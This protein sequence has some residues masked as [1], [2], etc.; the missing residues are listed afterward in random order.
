MILTVKYYNFFINFAFS[1]CLRLDQEKVVKEGKEQL[2]ALENELKDK[3][4]GGKT[5][6]LVDLV[7]DFLAY[8]LLII[9]EVVGLEVL[10]EEEFPKLFKWSHDFV[11]H[12]VVKENLPPRD[13]LIAYFKGY[14]IQIKI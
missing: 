5:I 11:S 10:N 4:F 6:G 2:K 1:A 13:K 14:F 3:F 12:G 9:Q 8:W 7:G